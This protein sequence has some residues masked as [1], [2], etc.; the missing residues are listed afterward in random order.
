MNKLPDDLLVEVAARAEQYQLIDLLPARRVPLA[1]GLYYYHPDSTVRYLIEYDHADLLALIHRRFEFDLHRSMLTQAVRHRAGRV[2]EYLLSMGVNPTRETVDLAYALDG[3]Q[4]HASVVGGPTP[5][6]SPGSPGLVVQATL[7]RYGYHPTEYAITLAARM[8]H[9]ASVRQLSRT[10]PPT[11][12]VLDAAARMGHLAVVQYLHQDHRVE[13]SDQAVSGAAAGGH[14][15]LLEYLL[16]R[17]SGTVSDWMMQDALYGGHLET[18]ELLLARGGRV[19]GEMLSEVARDSTLP[20]RLIIERFSDRVEPADVIRL[21]DHQLFTRLVP[22]SQWDNRLLTVAAAVGNLAIVQDLIQYGALPMP[23][24]LNAALRS[25]NLA[26]VEYLRRRGLNWLPDAEY[27]AVRS[28]R[29][30]VVRYALEH[31]APHHRDSL[32]AAVHRR[33]LELVRYLLEHGADPMSA[34]L[35]TAVLLRDPEVIRLL[36]ERQL[37]VVRR[38]GVVERYLLERGVPQALAAAASLNDFETLER[39]HQTLL[40][41]LEVDSSEGLEGGP[42]MVL[43]PT[44]AETVVNQAAVNGHLRMVKYLYSLGYRAGRVA[45]QVAGELPTLRFLV[46][47]GATVSESMM[48]VAARGGHLLT[49]QYLE[50]L[51]LPVTDEALTGAIKYNQLSVVVYLTQVANRICRVKSRSGSGLNLMMRPEYLRVAVDHEDTAMLVYFR[52]YLARDLARSIAQLTAQGAIAL[53]D[54]VSGLSPAEAMTV[55]LESG[56][57]PEEFR[58]TLYAYYVL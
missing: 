11:R 10:I 38:Y 12:Y 32:T 29:L 34:E 3:D 15:P 20:R 21:N 2:I 37:E 1:L 55:I 28:G 45:D 14:R 6:S 19:T 54:S 9:L 18:V 57:L 30:A 40:T 49:V 43:S 25:G 16:A 58:A 42:G 17:W 27:Q 50:S 33:S 31:G 24:T 56:A 7:A 53:V 51:G 35:E 26:L 5:V 46:E 39:L 4:Y 47:Q 44:L 48:V 22:T 52:R 23:H 41:V 8:G 36:L 13:I